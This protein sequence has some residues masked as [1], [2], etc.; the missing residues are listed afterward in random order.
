MADYND[1]DKA[2]KVNTKPF[3]VQKPKNGNL[4]IELPAKSVVLIQLK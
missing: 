3:T 2:E 1:F 4:K